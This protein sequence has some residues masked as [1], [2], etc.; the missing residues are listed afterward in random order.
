MFRLV[1]HYELRLE[2]HSHGD[3]YALEHA[4]TKLMWIAP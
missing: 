4:T 3:E 2:E 1:E